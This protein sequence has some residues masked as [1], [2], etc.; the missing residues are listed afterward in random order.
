MSL[1]SKEAILDKIAVALGGRAAEELFVEKISTGAADDLDKV[2]KMA[3]A[4]VTVYGMNPQL[5]LLSYSQSNSSEQ[6]YKPYSEETG[7][8]I[9]REARVIVEEQYQRVKKLLQEKS[10]LM[11]GLA[12][13]LAEKETLVY[14]DLLDV[15][16]ER[17]Y[18]I[19]DQF[20]QFVTASGNPFTAGFEKADGKK[21]D[22]EKADGE[23]ESKETPPSSP[24]GSEQ[25][26]QAAAAQ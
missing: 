24:P 15:L 25:K 5:G 14:A 1:F 22:G 13:K 16:G 23:A 17:P 4:M 10:A 9:D 7:K 21:A 26:G 11:E 18:G 12:D 20:K 6:F 19:Q 3:Y 8:L 2:T